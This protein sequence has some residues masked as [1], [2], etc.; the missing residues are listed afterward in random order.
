MFFFT[1]PPPLLEQKNDSTPISPPSPPAPKELVIFN[2]LFSQIDRKAVCY[3]CIPFTNTGRAFSCPIPLCQ[4]WAAG[5]DSGRLPR[6]LSVPFFSTFAIH[7]GVN[8]PRNSSFSG[9]RIRACFAIWHTNTAHVSRG[10]V[11]VRFGNA[12]ISSIC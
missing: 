4:Q 7:P 3:T 11:R 5:P 6:P 10:R 12:R 8:D 9:R 2:H 1:P